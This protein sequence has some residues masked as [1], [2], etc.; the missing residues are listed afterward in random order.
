HRHARFAGH[1][2]QV[3]GAGLALAHDQRQRPELQ[4]LLQRFP[5][6]PRLQAVE[7][8]QLL[9]AEDLHLVGIDGVEV[10]GER[11]PA[12]DRV[13]GLEL[14]RAP[15]LPREPAQVQ[16]LAQLVEEFLG[17]DR[18]LHEARLPAPPPSSSRPRSAGM[19]GAARTASR[20]P[21]S[22]KAPASSER[23][24]RWSWARSPGETMA[25][26]RSTGWPSR[27]PKS[28]GC[29]RRRKAARG[30]ALA[31]LRQCGMATPRPMPVLPTASRWRR[32]AAIA[33]VHSGEP[34]PSRRAAASSTWSRFPGSTTS[35]ILSA[36][37]RSV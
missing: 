22:A 17:G 36:A 5:A 3:R 34:P 20:K 13:A 6:L 26:T 12:R 9:G 21:A 29:A 31:S 18:R 4:D 15:A 7:P 27:A 35:T 25:N 37:S 1:L 11:R 30:V 33:G 14:A 10:A 24:S 8:G 28:T 32:P 16:P 19:S 2:G 23:V